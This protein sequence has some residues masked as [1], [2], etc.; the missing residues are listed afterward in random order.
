MRLKV[1]KVYF[2]LTV[3]HIES[4]TEALSLAGAGVRKSCSQDDNKLKASIDAVKKSV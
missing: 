1:K 3:C 4:K 2:S